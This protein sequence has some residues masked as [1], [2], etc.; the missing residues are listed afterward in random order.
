MRKV[1]E[2]YGAKLDDNM[3]KN[4][5]AKVMA[6]N[7]WPAQMLYCNS[8]ITEPG[9]REGQEGAVRVSARAI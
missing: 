4:Y 9:R 8:P 5:G 7:V 2:V 1:T 3:A 6:W